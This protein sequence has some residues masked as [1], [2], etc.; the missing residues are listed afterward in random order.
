M[1]IFTRSEQQE[2]KTDKMKKHHRGTVTTFTQ[3]HNM[4]NNWRQ[5]KFVWFVCCVCVLGFC[6]SR[7][8]LRLLSFYYFFDKF[9][10]IVSS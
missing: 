6:V 5:V 9:V 1:Q 8:S 2:T 7:L 4:Y 3:K 10:L